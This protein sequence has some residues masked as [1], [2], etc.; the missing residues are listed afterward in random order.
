MG[1][2]K[3]H[4]DGQKVRFYDLIDVLYKLRISETDFREKITFT[5]EVGFVKARPLETYRQ[6]PFW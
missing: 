4:L 1:H 5:E 3:T 2:P 6:L